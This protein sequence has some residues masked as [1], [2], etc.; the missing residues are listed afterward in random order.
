VHEWLKA[1]AD[2]QGA[3]VAAGV[4]P[5]DVRLDGGSAQAT[6]LE[7]DGS[8]RAFALERVEARTNVGLYAADG[9]HGRRRSSAP[10]SW[11]PA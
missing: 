11:A 8:T 5:V 7:K 6:M 1:S 4:L 9:A 10:T 2:T 3:F